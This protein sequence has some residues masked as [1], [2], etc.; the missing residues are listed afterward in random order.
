M[1]NAVVANWKIVRV[2]YC[3]SDQLSNTGLERITSEEIRLDW[4]N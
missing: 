1:V 2:Y 4:R 3:E